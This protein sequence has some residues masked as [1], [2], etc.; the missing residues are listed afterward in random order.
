MLMCCIDESRWHRAAGRRAR[1]GH[2]GLRRLD[3]GPRARGPA[4]GHREA[5]LVSQAAKTLRV[6]G[7]RRVVTDGPYAETKEQFGGFHI[8]ECR[9]VDEALAIAARIPTLRVGGT[10]RGAPGGAA[11]LIDGVAGAARARVEAVWR[12]ESRRVLATLIRLLGD[13]DLRGG[14]AARRRS[15]R[16]SSNGRA[17]ACRR[18]RAPGSSP[19]AV[20]RRS[21]A[22]AGPRRAST[23]RARGLCRGSWPSAAT[24][25]TR[26][27]RRC[28]T[29]GCVSSSPAATP[30][31]RRTRRSR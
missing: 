24:R 14:G 20:S 10:D 4:S 22:S 11:H 9:D 12:D 31:S 28:R 27:T 21:T 26:P 18:T 25:R 7:G 16:P 2:E 1:C 17:T 30:R 3:R 6:Q 8:V 19:R 13:F 5:G 23:T 15:R 29:T